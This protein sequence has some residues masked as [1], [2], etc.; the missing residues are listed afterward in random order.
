VV[1]QQKDHMSA[2][3]PDVE[4]KLLLLYLVNKMDLPLSNNQI[5]QFALE[6]NLMGY[7][8]LQKTLEEMVISGYLDKTKD[9]NI[10]RYTITDEGFTVLEY[11]ERQIPLVVKDKINKYVIDNRSTI[12][13]DFEITANYFYD[14]TNNEYTVK[15]GSYED[16]KILMEINVSVVN[17]EQAKFICNNWKANVAKLYGT[18][19]SE[20]VKKQ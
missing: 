12:K 9:N 4:N 2:E 7:L 20:L 8:V 15:C 18:I 11:F 10:T 14:H 5:S 13:K 16:E 1:K 19:L 6:E 3:Y 17:K